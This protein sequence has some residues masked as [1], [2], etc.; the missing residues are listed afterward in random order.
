MPAEARLS[1]AAS[2]MNGA[3]TAAVGAMRRELQSRTVLLIT[4]LFVFASLTVAS[5]FAFELTDLILPIGPPLTN[6]FHASV[7]L[8]TAFVALVTIRAE[9]ARRT[10]GP[11]GKGPSLGATVSDVV[12]ELA[13]RIGIDVEARLFGGRT[14]GE[15]EAVMIGSRRIVRIPASRLRESKTNPQAFRFLIAHEMTHLASGDPRLDR[16]IGCAYVVWAVA[17]LA[18]IGRVFWSVGDGVFL[19]GPLGLDAVLRSLRWDIFPVL[20]NVASMGVLAVLLFLERRSAMRLREFH[21]DAGATELVGGRFDA[22]RHLKPN[23]ANGLRGWLEGLI[24]DH[25][26]PRDRQIALAQF[27]RAFQADRILFVLQG[28]FA[29]AIIE[30]LMQLLFVN[31][32]PDVSTIAERRRYLFE[33]LGRFPVSIVSTMIVA[34]S[35]TVLAQFLVLARL[36]ILIEEAG[37]ARRIAP[38]VLLVP[39]LVGL[40]ACLALL[41]SQTFLWEMS[42]KGWRLDAWVQADPD[43][44][45]VYAA[46]FLGI[47]MVTATILLDGG[48][49]SMTRVGAAVLSGVPVLCAFSAGLWFYH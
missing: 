8:A 39:I 30:I 35:L 47:A 31:A 9:A 18:S 36:R 6:V 23:E 48:R 45:S 12:A 44:A 40:G 22:I 13:G 4:I 10:V 7:L 46:S 24:A 14:E 1:R 20:V 26:G 42:Q 3:A 33:S 38:I 11:S 49:W 15:I 21:A 32:S 43:R 19:T 17:M 37:G 41:S 2:A 28:F 27:A 25:P 29:A 5:S 34:I 16:W